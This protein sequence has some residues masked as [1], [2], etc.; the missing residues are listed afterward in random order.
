MKKV[1]IFIVSFIVIHLAINAQVQ[2]T[3][4][5]A[6][7]GIFIDDIRVEERTTVTPELLSLAKRIKSKLKESLVRHGECIL[8]R[9]RFKDLQKI[10]KQE[11][12]FKND[13][14]IN[15]LKEFGCSIVVYGEILY[16]PYADEHIVIDIGFTDVNTFQLIKYGSEKILVQPNKSL[17]LDRITDLIELLENQ[18]TNRN[19]VLYISGSNSIGDNLMPNLVSDFLKQGEYIDSNSIKIKRISSIN[20]EVEYRE[21]NSN[22]VKFISIISKGSKDIEYS[23]MANPEIDIVMSSLSITASEVQKTT[24]CTDE[25]FFMVNEELDL[26]SLTYG[27]VQSILNGNIISWK[28]IG[29]E[30]PQQ[31]VIV[32]E[33]N[34]DSGTRI[35]IEK[36]FKLSNQ[37]NCQNQFASYDK[38]IDLVRINHFAIGYVSAGYLNAHPEKKSGIKLL[39]VFN[40]QNKIKIVREF[41][42]AKRLQL[43]EDERESSIRDELFDFINDK[44][45][46]RNTILK[47]GFTPM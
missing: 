31:D 28:Q 38:I 30:L 32:G 36:F 26:S 13:A 19:R 42:L 6:K 41:H 4:G 37:R 2:S 43:L 44:D 21:R 15:T 29:N 22:L 17:D 5:C 18:S 24:I 35:F 9:D 7:G 34:S 14:D 20:I 11:E 16:H 8:E 47:S 1:I 3:R 40:K 27:Q 12:L 10:K 23:L 39:Q 25:V 45:K 46:I 33:R